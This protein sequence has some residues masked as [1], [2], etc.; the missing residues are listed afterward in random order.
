MDM[1]RSGDILINIRSGMGFVVEM[2]D[3]GGIHL[4]D[5]F[6]G[7]DDGDDEEYRSTNLLGRMVENEIEIDSTP[8]DDVL[9]DIE[10]KLANK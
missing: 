9:A 6:S 3:N 4:T 8:I 10:K 1:I 5:I 7:K 2:D